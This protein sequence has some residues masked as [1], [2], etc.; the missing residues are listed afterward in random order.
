MLNKDGR[1]FALGRFGGPI[2]LAWLTY[3]LN[4]ISVCVSSETIVLYAKSQHSNL[5]VNVFEKLM[6]HRTISVA[7]SKAKTVGRRRT[8]MV[9]CG[10]AVAAPRSDGGVVLIAESSSTL[11]LLF[12][13]R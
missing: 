6:L 2:A 13:A 12:L 11:P 4:N 9:G 5:I 1:N 3:I 8:N 10:G 7:R